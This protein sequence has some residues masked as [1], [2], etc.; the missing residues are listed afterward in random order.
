MVA[1]VAGGEVA[2]GVVAEPAH[3]RITYARRGDGCWRRDQGGAAARCLVTTTKDL[4]AATVVQSHSRPGKPSP[5]L[6][7]LRPARVVETYS[8]GIKLALV[9]RGEADLYLNTYDAS[10]DWDI[11][12]GQILVEEAGGRVTNFL[13]QK[14]VYGLPGSLQKHGLLASNAPLNAGS[15][16]S[17]YANGQ[18][19]DPLTIGTAC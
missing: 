11:C 9:A 3:E 17:L 18:D 15:S 6:L 13:G 19:S 2:A 4:A 5:Q 8:A 14:P 7:A 1:F 10:H 12:A 16:G